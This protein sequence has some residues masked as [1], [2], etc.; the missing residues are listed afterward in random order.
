MITL[1]FWANLPGPPIA[2]KCAGTPHK[3]YRYREL[4]LVKADYGQIPQSGKPFQTG[5][6]R[7]RK[8][9][10]SGLGGRIAGRV[11]LPHNS[12]AKLGF[13]EVT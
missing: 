7:E 9:G 1:V 11:G 6:C 3:C 5:H 13:I 2:R 10:N 12:L 4:R 8:A